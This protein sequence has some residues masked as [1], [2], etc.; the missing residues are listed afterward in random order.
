[1]PTAPD[2][3]VLV[4]GAT[5]GLGLEVARRL[6]A[7]GS[8]VLA[9]GRD[10]AKLDRVV[11][12]LGDGA[13]GYLAD[14]GSLEQTREF[15]R[16]VAAEH[17]ELD[18]LINNAGVA[19]HERE[20]ST[21]G[22]ELDFAVNY[23]AHF[24][25]TIELL[26]VLS[27]TPGSR[28]VNVSSLGQTAIDFDD[29][30]LENGSWNPGRAYS[31][32]KLAQILF[33]VELAERLPLG[34]SPTVNALHPSTYMDTNMVRGVGSEPRTT[35]GDGAEAT[36]RLAVGDDVDGVSGRFYDVL[37]EATPDPQAS[38]DAALTRLWELSEELT[39]AHLP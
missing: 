11:A 12:E 26:P 37:A 34:G 13:S 35:V 14:L 10:Q 38:D 9:H 1:M 29:V 27:Q 33:T 8:T 4:T 5:D 25:I 36:L 31:Q 3:T 23:L 17:D 16:R 19:T 22:Y 15:A 32:S 18:I 20:T 21:D 2:H 28:I 24:L 7:S 6:A 30:M 39:G